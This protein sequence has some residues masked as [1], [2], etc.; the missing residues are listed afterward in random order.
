MDSVGQQDKGKITRPVDPEE[1]KKYKTERLNDLK[2][3][4]QHLV[5]IIDG[6]PTFQDIDQISVKD[7][8]SKLLKYPNPKHLPI[9]YHIPADL[10]D[11]K[12]AQKKNQ[13]V[14]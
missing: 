7:D 1:L 6:Q 13:S 8:K 10:S 14:K 9:Q 3:Q 5:S 12:P 2:I 4:N 11:D